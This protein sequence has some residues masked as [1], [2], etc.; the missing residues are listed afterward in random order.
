MD[1]DEF[2]FS[3][4]PDNS[5]MSGH[6]SQ[7]EVFSPY[8]EMGMMDDITEDTFNPFSQLDED[9][10]LNPLSDNV[11]SS[12]SPPMSPPGAIQN[13]ELAAMGFEAPSPPGQQQPSLMVD[14]GGLIVDSR[15]VLGSIIS[16]ILLCLIAII[17]IGMYIG[18]YF[19]LREI[20][21]KVN[22]LVLQIDNVW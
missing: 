5:H 7:Q 14:K 8:S 21:Y 15:V 12:G 16:I 9:L 19:L 4:L 1:L 2:Q 3:G 18:A 17:V 11:F 22:H 20:E 6:F 13:N 10:R